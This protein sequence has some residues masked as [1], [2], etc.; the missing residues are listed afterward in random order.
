MPSQ[1]QIGSGGQ[2]TLQIELFTITINLFFLPRRALLSVR[3][4][5]DMTQ[6]DVY[7]F[8]KYVLALGAGRYVPAGQSVNERYWVLSPGVWQDTQA[9]EPPDSPATVTAAA[10]P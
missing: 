7:P 4:L 3:P 5:A 9:P 6:V 2:R 10:L 1:L 8:K